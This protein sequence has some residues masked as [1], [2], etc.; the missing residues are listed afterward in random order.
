MISGEIAVRGTVD[1]ARLFGNKLRTFSTVST[2]VD[3]AWLTVTDEITN[4]SAEPG[5]LELLYHINFGPPLVSRCR[6]VLPLKKIA[7]RDAV[8]A[9]DVPT[10]DIYGPERPARPRSATSATWLPTPP[11]KRGHCCAR[12]AGTTA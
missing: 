7:P 5:Q 3:Q 6:V 4:V 10:W 2:K 1:E 8:T 9:A 11:G 12:L